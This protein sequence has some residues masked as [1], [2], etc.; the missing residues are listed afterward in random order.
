MLRLIA[1]TLSTRLSNSSLFVLK[2]SISLVLLRLLWL[3]LQK[4]FASTG[5]IINVAI[6]VVL[7]A[8]LLESK[9]THCIFL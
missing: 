6:N 3:I 7:V 9:F 5:L 8:A 1:V 2:F 4:E